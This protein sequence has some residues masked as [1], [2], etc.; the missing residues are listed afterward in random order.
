MGE[1]CI[2]ARRGVGGDRQE[3][4]ETRRGRRDGIPAGAGGQQEDEER[5]YG[6]TRREDIKDIPLSTSPAVFDRR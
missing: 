1:S 3:E 2:A 5:V 4:R 6:S